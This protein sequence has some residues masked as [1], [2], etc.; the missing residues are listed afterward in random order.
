MATS[1]KLSEIII[2]HHY[3][4]ECKLDSTHTEQRVTFL[5]AVNKSELF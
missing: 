2:R 1:F 3:D 4:I 5:G